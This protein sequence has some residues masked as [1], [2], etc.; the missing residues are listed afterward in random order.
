MKRG[1]AKSVH[2]AEEVEALTAGPAVEEGAAVI[3]VTEAGAEAVVAGDIASG[4][5]KRN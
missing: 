2:P 5:K 4:I 3:V 1:L